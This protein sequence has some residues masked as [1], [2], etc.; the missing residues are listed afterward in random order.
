M[1]KQALAVDGGVPPVRIVGA[2]PATTEAQA[3][4]TK[5]LTNARQRTRESC[6]ACILRQWRGAAGAE[7]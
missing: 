7:R 4:T 6:P 3:T 1:P 2:R 5:L